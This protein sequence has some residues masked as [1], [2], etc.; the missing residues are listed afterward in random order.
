MLAAV[1]VFE[2]EEMKPELL[3]A[4]AIGMIGTT[5]E[6]WTRSRQ[7]TDETMSQPKFLRCLPT[8][9]STEG[10]K[11]AVAIN[12]AVLV[13]VPTSVGTALWGGG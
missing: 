5:C 9:W 4:G 13:A 3:A 7:C 2:V 1:K 11:L 6:L 8:L 10:A 12:R